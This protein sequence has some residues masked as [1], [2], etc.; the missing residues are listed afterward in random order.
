MPTTE[1]FMMAKTYGKDLSR[2]RQKLL[3]GQTSGGVVAVAV[4]VVVKGSIILYRNYS[5]AFMCARV[6]LF[7]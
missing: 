1:K 5:L 7:I 4:A 3:P 2:F 6:Q